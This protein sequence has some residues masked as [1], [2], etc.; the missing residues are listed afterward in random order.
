MADHS[1]YVTQAKGG[2]ANKGNISRTNPKQGQRYPNTM[3]NGQVAY[4]SSHTAAQYQ[5]P[6][7]YQTGYVNSNSAPSNNP[8]HTFKS[9]PNPPANHVN[10]LPTHPVGFSKSAPS[11][12]MAPEQV[13]VP[14]ST[15][16]NPVATQPTSSSVSTPDDQT[17][18]VPLIPQQPTANVPN[19]LPEDLSTPSDNFHPVNN[20]A[21][22]PAP[23]SH[24]T[25]P[26]PQE[27][28]LSQESCPPPGDHPAQPEGRIDQ[29]DPQQIA[30]MQAMMS[31]MYMSQMLMNPWMGMMPWM[32]FY[33]YSGVPPYLHSQAQ[34]Q[35]QPYQGQYH[36]QFP[37]PPQE[38]Q[39]PTD[40]PPKPDTP[41][42]I[43]LQQT[44]N[45]SSGR[46]PDSEQIGQELNESVPVQDCS[47]VTLSDDPPPD[48]CSPEPLISNTT[49][50]SSP[51]SSRQQSKLSHSSLNDE[52]LNYDTGHT[53]TEQSHGSHLPSQAD[54]GMGQLGV[55]VGSTLANCTS[56][57]NWPN[58]GSPTPVQQLMRPKQIPIAGAGPGIISSA[59]LQVQ[60]TNQVGA[61]FGPFSPV[62][63]LANP[64]PTT[65]QAFSIGSTPGAAPQTANTELHS[66]PKSTAISSEA[67]PQPSGFDNN[68]TAEP[69]NQHGIVEKESSSESYQSNED[70]LESHEHEPSFVQLEVGGR[71]F[72]VHAASFDNFPDSKL[73]KIIHY[74]EPATQNLSGAYTFDRD[75]NMFEV[76]LSFVRTGRLDLPPYFNLKA[77]EREAEFFG[78]KD[79]MFEQ[80]K[81]ISPGSLFSFKRCLTLD[82]ELQ[83]GNDKQF[84]CIA[85]LDSVD[86]LTFEEVVCE[87]FCHL[88]M[89]AVDLTGILIGRKIIYD[90]QDPNAW[91]GTQHSYEQK[92]VTVYLILIRKPSS[93]QP[94]NTT[95][96]KANI[97]YSTV[98]TFDTESHMPGY[99]R[100]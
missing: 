58:F 82:M 88:L 99:Y 16:S 48:S 91:K 95:S 36:N 44:D 81:Q 40:P 62:V 64:A 42:S 22:S 19:N 10:N 35:A 9:S 68:T 49:Q 76:I 7:Q 41:S 94:A 57:G 38:K 66:V 24:D 72:Q 70:D 92:P 47:S 51:S 37:V 53:Y 31:N 56:F 21:P 32:P 15:E 8:N 34:A 93:A 20:K 25:D 46:E 84:Q 26:E 61:G 74:T 54:A 28:S 59:V 73:Y 23:D 14:H 80:G 85:V 97:R 29:N 86:H 89:E 50:S 79:Y 45:Y 33:P 65:S 1:H 75:S 6:Y 60:Q 30:Q 52:P 18:A 71:S 27:S 90:N 5:Q 13:N 78:M 67:P 2:G 98:F 77:I 96:C 83:P 12:D 3:S 87:G 63:P 69:R 4:K 43:Q 100:R 55:A 17:S 39:S 11:P